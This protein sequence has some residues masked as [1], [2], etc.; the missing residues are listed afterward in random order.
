MASGKRK[1]MDNGAASGGIRWASDGFAVVPV[2]SEEPF[3]PR[4]RPISWRASRSERQEALVNFLDQLCTKD[5]VTIASDERA[6]RYYRSFFRSLYLGGGGFRHSYSEICRLVYDKVTPYESDGKLSDSV[7]PELCNLR[8]NLDAVIA[9]LSVLRNHVRRME[10]EI[11]MKYVRPDSGS[12]A[13]GLCEDDEEHQRLEDVRKDLEELE[14]IVK[15]VTKLY[16]HVS[17]EIERLG[18]IVRQNKCNSD[19]ILEASKNVDK[20]VEEKERQLKS[21]SEEVEK[22]KRDVQ[23]DNIAVLGIFASVM[24]VVNSA[25]SFSS[26]SL[27]AIGMGHGVV[28]VLLMAVI[29][30]YVV[31]NTVGVMLAFVWR[32]TFKDKFDLGEWPEKAWRVANRVLVVL[33]VL[34][35]LTR[36]PW[37]RS[38]VGLPV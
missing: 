21:L 34:L 31:I 12:V 7:P 36:L 20:A 38:L 15:R 5:P 35:A 22:T 11:R 24:L 16:D 25:V 32:M 8:P 10:Y 19:A 28:P 29:V 18:Y 27:S 37:F 26:A 1:R 33:I 14:E 23:R 2:E 9:S 6:A 4:I 13:V 17:M 3:F 30:G